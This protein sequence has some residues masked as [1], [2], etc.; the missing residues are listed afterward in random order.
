MPLGILDDV[1][2]ELSELL[3]TD[4]LFALLYTDGLTEA[5]NRNGEFFDMHGLKKWMPHANSSQYSAAQLR[6]DLILKLD[7]H[8]TTA[9]QTD[10]QTF[11]V[12]VGRTN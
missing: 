3:L 9:A 12:L 6:D 4:S 2:Y 10:D 1:D 5:R 8:Q 7:R 11:L